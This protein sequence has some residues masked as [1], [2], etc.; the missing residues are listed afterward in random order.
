MIKIT[1]VFKLSYFIKVKNAFWVTVPLSVWWAL[2]NMHTNY[3][4]ILSHYWWRFTA[5]TPSQS[6][7]KDLKAYATISVKVSQP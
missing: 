3:P 7:G 4:R 1:Q 5:L 2:C 6:V